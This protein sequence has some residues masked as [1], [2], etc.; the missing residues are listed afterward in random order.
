MLP[1]W[2]GRRLR[3][4]VQPHHVV[5]PLRKQ[6]RE[7]GLASRVSHRR[8]RRAQPLRQ[9]LTPMAPHG[10]VIVQCVEGI[11]DIKDLLADDRRVHAGAIKLRRQGHQRAQNREIVGCGCSCTRIGRVRRQQVVVGGGIRV[12][13]G[14][15]ARAGAGR[16]GARAGVG[17]LGA[18]EKEQFVPAASGEHR[19]E[20]PPEGA[21]RGAQ[22]ATRPAC[23]RRR[24]SRRNLRNYRLTPAIGIVS[25]RCGEPCARGAAGAGARFH[26][27]H[28]RHHNHRPLTVLPVKRDPRYYDTLCTRRRLG[29]HSQD[30]RPRRIRRWC[31]PQQLYSPE[32]GHA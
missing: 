24:P 18:S 13:I 23:F 28:V 11:A 29:T 32:L 10:G 27:R 4:P 1:L 20:G 21:P 12:R 9:M 15:P 19:T 31:P 2:G 25:V 8:L 6:E 3:F 14:T 22:E 5:G 26:R 16:V 30:C 7:C 17:S